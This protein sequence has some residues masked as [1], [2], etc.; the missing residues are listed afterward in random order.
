MEPAQRIQEIQREYFELLGQHLRNE[1]QALARSQLPADDFLLRTVRQQ[2]GG[3]V[4]PGAI[5]RYVSPLESNIDDLMMEVRL[6]WKEKHRTLFAAMCEYDGVCL[7]SVTQSGEYDASGRVRRHAVYFDT[8]C[9]PDPLCRETFKVNPKGE[10]LGPKTLF[11]SFYVSTLSLSQLA[12]ANCD[13]PMCIVYP[14]YFLAP[15]IQDEAQVSVYRVSAEGLALEYCRELFALS[16]LP[17]NKDELVEKVAETVSTDELEKVGRNNAVLR[18][19]G[20][21]L[22]QN[23]PGWAWFLAELEGQ[24]EFI[25]KYEGSPEKIFASLAFLVFFRELKA[26]SLVEGEC[27]GLLMD[28]AIRRASAWHCYKWKLRR[29]AKNT[30]KRLQLTEEDVALRTIETQ[31]MQW[32]TNV[33]TE[34]LVRLREEGKM[35]EMRR[36]F[37]VSRKR[38]KRASLDK[39]EKVAAEVR[40]ELLAAIRA[41]SQQLHKETGAWRKKMAW[42]AMG[43]VGTIALSIVSISLPGLLPLTVAS[44]AAS[45]I[46]LGSSARQALNEFF[47]GKKRVEFLR[48][49][50]IGVLATAK[51]EDGE[52]EG[53]R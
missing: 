47:K 19:S 40:G 22:G 4:V 37:R 27:D 16:E 23:V 41:H 48:R 29:D 42:S 1:R 3:I 52:S 8:V 25:L 15:F 18:E 12:L 38:L 24:T 20:I 6:F 26:V 43:A 49:R 21:V 53:N 39:F 9:V 13:R 50:P 51:D 14:P 35:E 5:G 32:L 34:D 31:E 7:L 30:M 28:P 2:K 17:E 44:G 33:K 45:A 10:S 36:L 46:G 11:W